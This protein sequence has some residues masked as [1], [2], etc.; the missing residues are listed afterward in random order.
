MK[1]NIITVT[2]ICH[3][4]V[5][6]LWLPGQHYRYNGF[7]QCMLCWPTMSHCVWQHTGL[8][9]S[10][11][12]VISGVFQ[13]WSSSIATY[14]PNNIVITHSLY[15]HVFS[16]SPVTEPHSGKWLVAEER[17]R[18]L[19]HGQHHASFCQQPLLFYFW[20]PYTSTDTVLRYYRVQY[21][22]T[23]GWRARLSVGLNI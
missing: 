10:F 13:A 9:L 14:V 6:C 7:I 3:F 12:H 19:C 17:L 11:C 2:W 8:C 16:T 23:F 1:G 15:R 5:S 21:I 18:T 20:V 22:C 4:S